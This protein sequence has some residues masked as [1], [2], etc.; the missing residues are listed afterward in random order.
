MEQ[1]L[2]FSADLLKKYDQTGPR[3]TSYPTAVQFVP[4]LNAVEYKKIATKATADNP[5]QPISLYFHIPFCD[6]ICYY[7]GCS[8]IVTRDHSKAEPYLQYLEKEIALQAALFK[9]RKVTQLH[10]GGGTPT[11]LNNQQI[12]HLMKLTDDAFC[13]D[14]SDQREFSIEIDPRSVD[15]KKIEVLAK[16]G[17]NR[18][19]LGVQDF[20]P[21]VQMAVNRIQSKEDTLKV[22]QHARSVGFKS[23]S[24]DLIYGLPKQQISTFSKTLDSVISARPDRVAVYSYAHIPT[25]FK[26]QKGIK[27]E[28]LPSSELKI[29][30]LSLT[31][32]K[33]TQA[34]Y[35]YIGMDHFSL[36]G[37]ELA[38]AQQQGTL[39]RNFQGY[40]THAE[41]DLIGLGLTSIGKVGNSYSQNEKNIEAYYKR[42]DENK[43]PTLRGVELDQDDI[44]RRHIISELMCHSRLLF[45]SIEKLFDIEFKSYF[46]QELVALQSFVEDNLIVLESDRLQIT[47]SG[48]ML[49]R[50][51]GMQFDA[52][53]KP[54]GKIGKK[55]RYSK[56][57]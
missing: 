50:N 32:E 15:N 30:L 14:K 8:K 20:D 9:N 18:L 22:M 5:L 11:F 55:G 45:P 33:L 16:V 54:G 29:Q 24:V 31:I 34:G 7:C 27:E 4:A 43:L 49:L 21:D 26:S 2:E 37:D 12:T 44:I 17:F 13:L 51:I 35:L 19:S 25:M 3:Y 42:L 36:P 40:S 46:N 23:I 41:C 47:P 1:R 48:R 56:L 39:H 10:W 57:I 28:Q 38:L 6:T 53:L 52:Y